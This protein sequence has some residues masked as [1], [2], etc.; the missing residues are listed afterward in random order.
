[1]STVIVE[2]NTEIELKVGD[3]LFNICQGDDG[4]LFVAAVGALGIEVTVSDDDDAQV[5]AIGSWVNIDLAPEA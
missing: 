1:M 4:T 2:K 3:K 5:T